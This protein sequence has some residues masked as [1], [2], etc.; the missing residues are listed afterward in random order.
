MTLVVKNSP[1]HAGDVRG[2]SGVTKGSDTPHK[3]H[4]LSWTES[5]LSCVC[6]CVCVCGYLSIYI[7]MYVYI[8]REI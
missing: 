7:C 2:L 4:I 3:Q 5:G 6:V 8:E 1:V